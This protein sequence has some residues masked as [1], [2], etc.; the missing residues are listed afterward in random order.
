[1][2]AR[3]YLCRPAGRVEGN[4]L[5]LAYP[6]RFDPWADHGAS[7]KSVVEHCLR[8]QMPLLI[9]GDRERPGSE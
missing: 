8:P 6:K 5:Y 2:M 7:N 1:M 9:C 4:K 3:A